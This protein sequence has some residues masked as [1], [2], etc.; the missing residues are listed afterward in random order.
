MPI[1]K[2]IN[3]LTLTSQSLGE[4][5]TANGQNGLN[6]NAAAINHFMAL[7]NQGAPHYVH[8]SGMHSYANNVSPHQ[9]LHQNHHQYFNHGHIQSGQMQPQQHQHHHPSPQQQQQQH[10]NFHQSHIV[11]STNHSNGFHNGS[12]LALGTKSN[13]QQQHH[14]QHM[15]HSQSQH[16]HHHHQTNNNSNLI[17]NNNDETYSPELTADENPFYYDKNKLLFDLHVERQRRHQSSH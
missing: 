16:H 14:H 10:P 2:R 17:N 6:G 13:Q 1:S 9:Q 15:H 4:Q 11:Q 8:Q 7:N 3:N 5:E 12:H